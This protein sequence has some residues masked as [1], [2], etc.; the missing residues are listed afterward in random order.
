MKA[1]SLVLVAVLLVVT[2]CTP[3]DAERSGTRPTADALALLREW[4]HRRSRAWAEGDPGALADL[5]TPGSRTGRRDRDMLAAYASRGLRV[6]GL[7]TQVGGA[8]LK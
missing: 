1:Q 2:A 3:A 8:A 4:D 6:T 5:Y 7:L